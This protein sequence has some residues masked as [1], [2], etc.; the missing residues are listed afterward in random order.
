V[1]TSEKEEGA[2]RGQGGMKDQGGEGSQ[3][4]GVGVKTKKGGKS[5]IDRGGERDCG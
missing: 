5:E 2:V 4:G 3:S 1:T